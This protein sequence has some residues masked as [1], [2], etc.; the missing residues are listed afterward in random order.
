[1]SNLFRKVRIVHS[2][3]Q[4]VYFVQEKSVYG[5]R[6]KSV[7][8]FPYADTSPQGYPFDIQGMAFEK[9]VRYAETL[10]ARSVVWERTNYS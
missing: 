3:K 4:S 10:L 9:A 1:M 5:L 2:P 8:S 7:K 6:W